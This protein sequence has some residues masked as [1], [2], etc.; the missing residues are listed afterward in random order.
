MIILVFILLVFSVV[1]MISFFVF[2]FL[3]KKQKKENAKLFA[4]AV[5]AKASLEYMTTL[6]E[7]KEDENKRLKEKNKALESGSLSNRVDA[8]FN[9]LS[10]NKN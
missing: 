10:N 7:L 5:K 1:F 3:Y 8:A 6:K 2:Y 9:L 4:E